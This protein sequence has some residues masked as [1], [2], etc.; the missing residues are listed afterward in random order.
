MS[1]ARTPRRGEIWMVD[2]DPGVGAEI[3]NLRWEDG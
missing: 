1:T 3:H 2:F